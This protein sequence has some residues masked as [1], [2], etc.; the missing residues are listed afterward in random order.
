LAHRIA[1]D[2]ID[3]AVTVL[4]WMLRA[5]V[6]AEQAIGILVAI[7]ADDLSLSATPIG[8]Q[9]YAAPL[10]VPQPRAM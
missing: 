9:G 8:Q 7:P 4:I 2:S 10:T 1:F 5:I 3:K 6:T